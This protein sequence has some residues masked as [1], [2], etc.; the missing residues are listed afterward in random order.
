MIDALATFFIIAI[1]LI[2]VRRGL[3]EEM[4]R[5]LGIIFATVFALRLYVD[6]GSFLMVWL[7]VDVW[8]LFVLSFI[9]IFSGVLLL[10]RFITKLIHFLF[11]SKSTK[12]VNRIMGTSFGIIKGLLVVMIFFWMFEL[13]PNRDTSNIVMKQSKL[14][15]RLINVRK[16]IITTFNWK[17]PVELGEKTIREFL[18]T[19]ENNNG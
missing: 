16:N 4:G 3:V 1:G 6:L 5:L 10:T 14:A 17:D 15:Q 13:L 11:L 8:L 19:M 2:G 9:I 7:P 18:N 12:W